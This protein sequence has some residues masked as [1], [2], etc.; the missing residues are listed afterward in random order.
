MTT[1]LSVRR[2]EN[3][4]P[5]DR[6]ILNPDHR[7][8]FGDRTLTAVYPDGV[9]ETEYI[10]GVFPVEN[11]GV[12]LPDGSVVVDVAEDVT[13]LVPAAAYGGSD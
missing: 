8:E 2:Y 11:G 10:V 1:E 9:D 13:A 7:L 3:V 6:L 4:E 5:F 12:E